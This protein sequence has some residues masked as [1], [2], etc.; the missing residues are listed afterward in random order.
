MI[1]RYQGAMMGFGSF[2]HSLVRAW[3]GRFGV[4]RAFVLVPQDNE[5]LTLEVRYN[6]KER[7]DMVTLTRCNW[8]TGDTAILYQGNL[9]GGKAAA[10]RSIKE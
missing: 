9:L 4:I 5:K 7:A 1:K 10:P 6:V 3:A 8:S 2:F